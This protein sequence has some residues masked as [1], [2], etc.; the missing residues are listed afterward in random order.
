[1]IFFPTRV[2]KL[3][4]PQDPSGKR[5]LQEDPTSSTPKSAPV[6][7][8]AIN[9]NGLVIFLIVSPDP[10][11]DFLIRSSIIIIIQANVAT[12]LI[13]LSIQTMY[14]PDAKAMLI[15]AGYMFGI[16]LF[17]W[18]FRSRRIWAI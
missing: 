12:G 2:S 15:L 10:D 1:M 17:A 3:K 7:F 4:D 13:N 9:K 16:C 6:L 14:T 5:I 8:E 11:S 18:I